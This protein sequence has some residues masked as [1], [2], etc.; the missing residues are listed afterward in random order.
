MNQTE[1]WKPLFRIGGGAALLAAVLFRRNIGAEVSLFTGANAIP[2]SAEEWFSLLQTKPFVGM[3]FLAVF[4]L[5]NYFLE[6]LVFLALAAMLWQVG[7]SLA[8]MAL[9]S[10][11]GGLFVLI[12][13]GMLYGG[14]KAQGHLQELRSQGRQAR[15]FIF[16]RWQD[17]DSDG[18][19]TYFVAFAFTVGQQI[20]THAEQNSKLFQKYR[21]GDT[22]TVRYIPNQPT[23]CQVLF[24]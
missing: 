10:G 24:S 11:L 15:A 7:K 23:I 16:D 14:L 21:I 2:F 8:A 3:S 19:P 17:K 9:A 20:I 18:D 5:C 22:V 6:G 13:L 4:D 1:T 12:G